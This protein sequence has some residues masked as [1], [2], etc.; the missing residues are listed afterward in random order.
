MNTLQVL[1]GLDNDTEAKVYLVGGYVRD[2]LRN[3]KNDDLDIVV[4]ELSLKGIE[5]YLKK[6]GS[7]KRVS[8]AKTTHFFSVNILLFKAFGDTTEAQISL[9]RE[10][11]K[12][13]PN[14]HNTLIQDSKFRDFKMNAMYLS[15]NYETKTNVIDKVKGREDIANQ[16]ISTV[17]KADDRIRESPIRMLRAISLAARLNYTID[18]GLLRSIEK[19]SYLILRCPVEAIREYFNEILLSRKPSKYLKIM[20]KTKLLKYICPEVYRCVGVKQ[21]KRYHKY[22]VYTHLVYTCDNTSSN[23]L[24]LRLAG[25]LH[26]IGKADTRKEV[27]VPNQKDRITFHKHEM[28]STKLAK[29]FLRRLKYSNSISEEILVLVKHHMYHY[30]REWTDGAV[31]KFIKKIPLPEQFLTKDSIQSFP[32]FQLR[33]AERKGNGLKTIPITD[34]QIDFENRLLS[35][36]EKSHSLEV[37][38][39]AINGNTLMDIFGLKAGVGIGQILDYLLEIVL[40]DPEKNNRLSLLELTTEYLFPGEKRTKMNSD[41]TMLT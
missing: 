24:A 11:K 37:R 19:N 36:Y 20:V 8:L 17:G 40:N 3:K 34:R 32:L 18:G 35:V 29:A 31:R 27:K 33:A 10:G 9:P 7:I 15:V 30:T 6:Y 12:Q 2:L 38:N 4:K 13:I 1:Q 22:D 21:D 23:S 26:D 28:V 16:R 41:D 25:I 14:L 39:L 5:N